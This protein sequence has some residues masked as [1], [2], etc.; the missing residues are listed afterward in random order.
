[1]EKIEEIKALLDEMKELLKS[2]S[3]D[4]GTSFEEIWDMLGER[5]VLPRLFDK[6]LRL[7]SLLGRKEP[8]NEPIEDTFKDIIGYCILSILKLRG[9]I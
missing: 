5:S 3:E 6:M 8:K 1:M 2:K 9:K 7:E 4:Y